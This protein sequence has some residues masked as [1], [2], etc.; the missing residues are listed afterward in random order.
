MI[1][2][3]AFPFFPSSYKSTWKVRV[4]ETIFLVHLEDKLFH[5]HFYIL[6]EGKLHN[7]SQRKAFFEM[8]TIQMLSGDKRRMNCGGKSCICLFA[9]QQKYLDLCVL[10]SVLAKWKPEVKLILVQNNLKIHFLGTLYHCHRTTSMFLLPSR[11]PSVKE[12]K[13]S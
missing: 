6:K 4:K 10:E 3:S 9:L 8:G 1:L 12:L 2:K 7:W 13:I 5:I 11:P